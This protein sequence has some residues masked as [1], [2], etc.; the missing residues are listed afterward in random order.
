MKSKT[1]K[2]VAT[3]VMAIGLCGALLRSAGAYGP[4]RQTYTPDNPPS[5]PVFNSMIWDNSDSAGTLDGLPAHFDERK[6]VWIRECD[7]EAN[8]EREISNEI[9]YDFGNPD[10]SGK[11]SFKVVPGKYYEISIYYH[12]NAPDSGNFQ[13]DGDK[14]VGYGNAA[15]FETRVGVKLPA[16]VAAGDIGII[17]GRI[18]SA[19]RGIVLDDGD[20]DDTVNTVWDEVRFYAD[21]SVSIRWLPGSAVQHSGLLENGR[22]LKST[23]VNGLG[24]RGETYPGGGAVI[25]SREDEQNDGVILGGTEYAGR[26][27][28]RILAVSADAEMAAAS[29]TQHS[30]PVWLAALIASVVVVGGGIGIVIITRRRRKSS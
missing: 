10:E 13:W 14:K 19:A 17:E 29:V 22:Q 6:F 4:E 11:P 24:I 16:C 12:N 27:T 23:V 1:R 7:A 15:A 18:L 28:L 26:V 2:L 30:V 25:S 20:G 3:M 21:E 5:G 8:M 9:K